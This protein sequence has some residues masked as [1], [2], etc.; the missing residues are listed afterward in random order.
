MDSN[1]ALFSTAY[2]PPVFN[3]SQMLRNN[4]I[5]LEKH[6]TYPKQ[7]YRN[8]CIIY[9]SNGPLPL[10]IPVVKPNGNRTKI[11]D[12]K[13]DNGD[14]WKKEHWRAI[15]TAYKNSAYY[16]FIADYFIKYFTKDWN[17]LW[18]FNIDLLQT[19]FNILDI[20]ITIQETSVF[21]QQYPSSINDYR[22][23]ITP[24]N[25]HFYCTTEYKPIQYFQVFGIKRGFEPNL[26]IFDLICN[27]GK[28]SIQYLK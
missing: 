6:E 12:V 24:K 11:C 13:I 7:T 15:E 18:D 10:I 26:S 2:L 19:V 17:Y 9:S 23:C 22:Y 25:R 8:R 4:V 20:D 21:I 5:L 28:E 3:V 14:K 1:L 16:E 27:C